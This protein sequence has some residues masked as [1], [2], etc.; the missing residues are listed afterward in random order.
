M[1]HEAMSSAPATC[2]STG[3]GPGVS[4]RVANQRC[5]S[6]ISSQN[7]TYSPNASSCTLS[8]TPSASIAFWNAASAGPRS[9]KRDACSPRC[10]LCVSKPPIDVKKPWRVTPSCERPAMSFAHWYSWSPKPPLT[11]WNA[12]SIALYAAFSASDSASLLFTASAIT[13]AALACS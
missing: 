2:S 6:T 11:P 5:K 4:P 3:A 9:L 8:A 7:G 1:S 10:A 12:L 13:S